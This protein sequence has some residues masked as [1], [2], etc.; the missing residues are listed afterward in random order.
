MHLAPRTSP[1]PTLRSRSRPSGARRQAGSPH[2]YY[3]QPTP[4]L[5]AHP[6]IPIQAL[7]RS[8]SARAES[9][10][11]NRSALDADAGRLARRRHRLADGRAAV[12]FCLRR[13]EGDLKTASPR[14]TFR[15]PPLRRGQ[16]LRRFA[17]RQ[18]AHA[19]ITGSPHHYYRQPAP[20]LQAAHTT[21]T[22]PPSDP[23][24]GP[25]ALAVGARRK[26]RYK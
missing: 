11:T 24:P 15:A 16:A 18:A 26:R 10:A 19:T 23:D 25:P 17:V 14:R 2:Q 13:S 5:Q 7:R 6:P 8:P 1:T 22:G 20:L 12:F 9:V 4:L 3:R 21:I